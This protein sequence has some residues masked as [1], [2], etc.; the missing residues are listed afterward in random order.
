MK[1]KGMESK[2]QELKDISLSD[3]S[4]PS[5]REPSPLEDHQSAMQEVH[6]IVLWKTVAERQKINATWWRSRM[7]NCVTS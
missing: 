6:S 2:L 7:P 1:A 5:P 4:P 3:R